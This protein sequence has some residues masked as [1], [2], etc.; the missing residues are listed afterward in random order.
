MDNVLAGC[1]YRC[2]SEEQAD[3]EAVIQSIMKDWLKTE[4]E[5]EDEGMRCLIWDSEGVE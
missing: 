3:T 5:Q 1:A 2:E 4:S